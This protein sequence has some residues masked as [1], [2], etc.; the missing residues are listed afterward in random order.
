LIEKETKMSFNV[1][2]EEIISGLHTNQIVGTN[3]EHMPQ[4]FLRITLSAIFIGLTALTSPSQL[5]AQSDGAKLFKANCTIC[6]G[7]DGTGNTPTGKV[8]KAK[9]LKLPD[10]QSKSDAALTDVITKGEGKMPAFG[11]KFP[12]DGIKSLVGYIRQLEKQ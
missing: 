9:D 12:A 4:M 10:V 1:P 8:L 6:H 3:G 5:M 2:L 11:S 7:A